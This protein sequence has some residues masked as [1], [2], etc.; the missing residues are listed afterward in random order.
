MKTAAEVSLGLDFSLYACRFRF[1]C[2][3]T[4][5]FAEGKSG[6]LL[7]GALGD[8][9]RS[10]VCHSNCPGAK[11]CPDRLTC[12]YARF[13]EP[14]AWSPGPSG[15]AD[16]PR[17]FV[18]RAAH[19]DGRTSV[20]GQTFDF[21]L[22]VFDLQE[23]AVI[24]LVLTF[25]VMAKKGFGPGRGRACPETVVGLNARSER[26]ALI[27]DNKKPAFPVAPRPITLTLAPLDRPVSRVRVGFATPT[28]LK[29]GECLVAEPQFGV[30]FARI[31]DR[32]S[33][34]RNLYG[35][36]PLAIDFR[37]MAERAARV[38]MTAC[39][40]EY[41]STQRRSCK[42]GQISPL[43]GFVGEVEYEGDL[44]EFVPYLVAAQWIGVGRQTVWGKGALQLL[45]VA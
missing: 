12:P 24:W 10:L 7:R 27:Y 3:D 29:A 42:T 18:L 14:T 33:T 13:F 45:G 8:V 25:V 6:N 2:I 28:E 17:P 19:L 11:E 34:L 21:D 40:L 44:A 43:G 4:L 20:P 5:H 41:K 30:L 23:A 15:L 16:W 38:R 37:G 39:R 26:A 32:A 9:M 36:G 1:R 31:R 35:S 22:H